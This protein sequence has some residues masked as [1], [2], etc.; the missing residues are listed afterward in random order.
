MYAYPQTN[1]RNKTTSETAYSLLYPLTKSS[2]YVDWI[3]KLNPALKANN[4]PHVAKHLSDDVVPFS[5][6]QFPVFSIGT[7]IFRKP[8]TN[9]PEVLINLTVEEIA[10]PVLA[11]NQKPP[12]ASGCN[13]NDDF[14]HYKYTV[15]PKYNTPTGRFRYETDY[16]T[17]QHEIAEFETKEKARAFAQIVNAVDNSVISEAMLPTIEW[18]EMVRTNDYHSLITKLQQVVTGGGKHA[19]AQYIIQ[20][21]G[22]TLDQCNQDPV[23]FFNQFN[24]LECSLMSVTIPAGTDVLKLFTSIM[25]STKM[26]KTNI[27]LIQIKMTDLLSR[28]TFSDPQELQTQIMASVT[29]LKSME[30]TST[31][32]VLIQA[33]VA[34]SNYDNTKKPSKA[35]GCYNCAS[36]DHMLRDCPRSQAKCGKCGQIGHCTQAHTAYTEA[37]LRYQSRRTPATNSPVAMLAK[38]RTPSKTA[39]RHKPNHNSLL[40][41]NNVS[42]DESEDHDYDDEQYQTTL[43]LYDETQSEANYG[44]EELPAYVANSH[45][46]M[47]DDAEHDYEGENIYSDEFDMSNNMQSYITIMQDNFMVG[48]FCISVNQ[49]KA[50]VLTSYGPICLSDASFKPTCPSSRPDIL[51]AHITRQ[52][53]IMSSIEADVI[54]KKRFQSIIQPQVVTSISSDSEDSDD[55]YSTVSD[56]SWHELILKRTARTAFYKKRTS[57]RNRKPS[58]S[59]SDVDSMPLLLPESDSDDNSMPLLSPE[60]DSDDNSMPLLLPESD[61]DDNSMPLLL[62]ES[63]SEYS[64][65]DDDSMPMLGH[66]SSSDIDSDNDSDLQPNLNKSEYTNT[67]IKSYTIDLLTSNSIKILPDDD[68]FEDLIYAYQVRSNIEAGPIYA[69]IDTGSKANLIMIK[70]LN[71]PTFTKISLCSGISVTGIDNTAPPIPVTHTGYHPVIGK[72]YFGNFSS[73]LIGVGEIVQ[74]G[75]VVH[76]TADKIDIIR[77]KNNAV[78][79][80]ARKNRHGLYST[81]INIEP[82]VIKAYKSIA[83]LSAYP[84]RNEHHDL[85]APPIRI[86]TP[87]H[88]TEVSRA[89]EVLVLHDNLSHPSDDVLKDALDGNIYR[90]INL[91]PKDVDN[92]RKLFGK[93]PSCLQG[94]MR[95]PNHDPSK[96]FQTDVP[97]EILYADLKKTEVTCIAGHTQML[98]LRDYYSGYIIVIGMKDKTTNSIVNALNTAIASFASYGHTTKRIVFDHEATFVAVQGRIHG[99]QCTYTPSGLHNRYIE[100]AIQD[101]GI[102]KQCAECSLPYILDSRLEV[103]GYENAARASNM[104]PNV[105]TGRNTPY[106]IITGNQP[107]VPELKYGQ[108]VIA[109]TR[110]QNQTKRTEYAI[111]LHHELPND[112]IVFNP[113]TSQILSRHHVEATDYYPKDWKLPKRPEMVVDGTLLHMNV[114]NPMRNTVPIDP[115]FV[116]PVLSVEPNNTYVIPPEAN[117]IV[118]PNISQSSAITSNQPS[119]SI[120]NPQL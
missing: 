114:P 93:C 20:L 17:V 22:L 29:T 86:D 15:I 115:N 110:P 73:N 104:L 85:E 91:L 66:E 90:N 36:T 18:N 118:G 37:K 102:K 43:E 3:R 21:I 10:L 61:S 84:I 42:I 107:T 52:L 56:I 67:T 44:S 71:H 34:N 50:E 57:N 83:R 65:S 28:N 11:L 53:I 95:E 32:G 12:D 108:S 6:D 96:T 30:G 113:S 25:F 23:L 78:I 117:S 100:R 8:I 35:F 51:Q 41:A 9:T 4:C 103:F 33:N 59:D 40:R 88:A 72:C 81:D 109:Y 76:C 116:P 46:T 39:P 111:F 24:Q 49:N 54:A 47:Y 101:I 27:P 77:T 69:Y 82:S 13:Y 94:K 7:K 48:D 31:P 55:E 45:E 14:Y 120:T 2:D 87:M 19:L 16:K 58:I 1:N 80:S 75:L 79:Y 98:I 119:L 62:P 89:K 105:R 70:H 5:L 38:R 74:R 64:D 106:K 60:S 112:N 63:D 97:G 92:A 68:I 99:V 26:A